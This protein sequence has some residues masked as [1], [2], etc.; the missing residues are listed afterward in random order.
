[1]Q[2]INRDSSPEKVTNMSHSF[3]KIVLVDPPPRR[4][5]E[6][7]EFRNYP[8]L[9]LAYIAAYLRNKG[10]DC[11]VI[12][13]KFERLDFEELM[14]RLRLLG[15]SIVG[16]TATTPEISRAHEVAEAAKKNLNG[17]ITIVGGAHA[18]ALP[19]ET[20]R[21]FPAFDMAVFGEGELTSYELVEAVTNGNS[22]SDIKG[23][24]YR[25]DNE[26]LCNSRRD[27]IGNLDELP[28]PAWDL[29][30]RSKVYPIM[31]TRG[32]PFRCNFCMRA[33]GIS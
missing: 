25:K 29:Y 21:E 24:C 12:D 26:V 9:G 10:I 7:P 15:P 13:A 20:L 2:I 22:L 11:S 8:Y 16:I 6:F 4:R 27:W 30:P 5:I 28:F 14:K 33:L 18:T 19:E 23:L 32:C 17:V 31:A 1:M 3:P